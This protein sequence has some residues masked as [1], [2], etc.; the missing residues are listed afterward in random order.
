MKR[1]KFIGLGISAVAVAAMQT[2]SK[3]DLLKELPKAFADKKAN[4]ALKD[5]YGSSTLNKSDKVKLKVPDIAENGGAV[6]IT[7]STTI[8]NPKTMSVFIEGNPRPL[9]VAW[10]IQEGTLPEFSTRVKMRKTSKVI[11]VV[12][13]TNGKIYSTTKQVKVT[14][15]G[16]GG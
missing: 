12:E 1:R 16:C 9:A 15:G 11:L 8:P 4:S 5:L 13:D 2:I 3:A 7:V 6:P 10:E 14:V